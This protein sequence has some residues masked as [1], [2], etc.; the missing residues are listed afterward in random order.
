MWLYINKVEFLCRCSISQL[1]NKDISLIRSVQ[2][3]WLFELLCVDMIS[4]RSGGSRSAS[5]VQ[6]GTGR[7]TLRLRS[8]GPATVE[9]L[10]SCVD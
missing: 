8:K 10:V 1:E 9:E 3:D 6:L 2:S 4:Q 5:G 7:G